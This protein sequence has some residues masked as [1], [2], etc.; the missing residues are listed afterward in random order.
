[1]FGVVRSIFG[2]SSPSATQGSDTAV[3]EAPQSKAEVTH[4]TKLTSGT[5]AQVA[6]APG[7][8]AGESF[9]RICPPVSY[10][11]TVL[12]YIFVLCTCLTYDYNSSHTQKNFIY[13]NSP[14]P[15]PVQIIVSL[16]AFLGKEFCTDTFIL[17]QEAISH[18]LTLCIA[19]LHFQ[20]CF[21]CSA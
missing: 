1:M 20:L 11:P 6:T 8:S 18:I 9:A 19:Y 14:T 16:Q 13:K 21:S 5:E 10:I 4:E 12:A 17:L 2:G 15:P 3:S 7:H